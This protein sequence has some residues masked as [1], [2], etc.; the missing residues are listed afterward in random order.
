MLPNASCP[1]RGCVLHH[2][3]GQCAVWFGACF[4]SFLFCLALRQ[5]YRS[6]CQ[7][8]LKCKNTIFFSY[9]NFFHSISHFA[10]P[11]APRHAFRPRPVVRRR[12]CA[13]RSVQGRYPGAVGGSLR[14]LF[15]QRGMGI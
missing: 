7:S 1:M 14:G 8:V 3:G 9:N 15:A 10:A 12:R 6:A 2:T 4:A 5:P 11:V 13:V